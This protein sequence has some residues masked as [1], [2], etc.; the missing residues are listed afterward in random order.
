VHVLQRHVRHML[1]KKNTAMPDILAS[2][3][4]SGGLVD[5]YGVTLTPCYLHAQQYGWAPTHQLL[6]KGSQQG[7]LGTRKDLQP[8]C[9]VLYLTHQT[10]SAWLSGSTHP[11]LLS[12]K[13]WCLGS[14]CLRV[15]ES[16]WAP[17][18][19]Y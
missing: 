7:M 14:Y 5:L 13:L 8:F 15:P 9:V 1:S 2:L 18:S 17:T 16:A 11:S 4:G 6:V 12:R 10:F 3:H 19:N